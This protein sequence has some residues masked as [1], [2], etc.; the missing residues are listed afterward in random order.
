MGEI[1]LIQQ[2]SIGLA[3]ILSLITCGIYG[4]YW[5]YVITNEVGYLSDDPSFTGGKT[6]LFSI[7]T[8]GIYTL[9]WYYIL[10]G[11]I[12]NAQMK[13]GFPAKDDGVLL[14]VLGIFG[15]GIVSMAIAQSNVNN[16][17]R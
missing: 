10:G 1:N 7:I 16:M 2:R 17:V 11:K 4:I 3:I 13:K 6:I 12:A 14:V 9:F 8:C 5:M 15:L